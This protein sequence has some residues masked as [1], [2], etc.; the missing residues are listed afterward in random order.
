M[1]NGADC[2]YMGFQ[3]NTNARNFA[4][5]NFDLASAGE[6]VR[7]AHAKG[8][9]VLLALNT[10]PQSDK[11]ERWQ[12]PWTTPPNSASTRSSWPTPA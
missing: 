5:L 12:A 9:K 8:A 6:G 11:W 4:G 7:Y 3:D 10:Y 2:V 1:D